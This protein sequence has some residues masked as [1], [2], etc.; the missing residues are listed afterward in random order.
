MGLVGRI[1]F[2]D[3]DWNVYLERNILPEKLET[4]KNV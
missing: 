3:N 1:P 4:I 2:N